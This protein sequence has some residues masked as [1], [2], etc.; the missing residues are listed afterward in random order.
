MELDDTA[1]LCVI[2]ACIQG[3]DNGLLLSIFGSPMEPRP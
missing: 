3:R 1:Y 2:Q